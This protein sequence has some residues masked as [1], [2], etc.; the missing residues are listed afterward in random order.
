MVWRSC[1]DLMVK[2][3]S[4][5]PSPVVSGQSPE[6]VT[7]FWIPPV[8]SLGWVPTRWV[9]YTFDCGATAG[10]VILRKVEMNLSWLVGLGNPAKL[11]TRYKALVLL[12]R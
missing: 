1:Q 4:S 11:L 8:P 6:W 2:I 5:Y 3:S 10:P 12:V 9:I 7:A